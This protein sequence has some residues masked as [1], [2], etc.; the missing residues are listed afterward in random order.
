MTELAGNLFQSF[1]KNV[2]YDWKK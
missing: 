2:V 1:K